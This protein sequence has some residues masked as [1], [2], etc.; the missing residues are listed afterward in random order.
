MTIKK[1]MLVAAFFLGIAPKAQALEYK[2]DFDGTCRISVEDYGY[3]NI[4]LTIGRFHGE[5]FPEGKIVR[6]SYQSSEGI[7]PGKIWIYSCS[8]N[9]TLYLPGYSW[10]EY[11]IESKRVMCWK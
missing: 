11:D 9:S 8:D 5:E 7:S 10:G 1:T 3:N 6:C 2:M 4:T